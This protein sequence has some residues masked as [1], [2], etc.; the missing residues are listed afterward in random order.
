MIHPSRKILL[1]IILCLSFCV[2]NHAFVIIPQHNGSI[3]TTED[4]IINSTESTQRKKFKMA[5]LAAKPK[6]NIVTSAFS[7]SDDI[8]ALEAMFPFIHDFILSPFHV[9]EMI[10]VATKDISKL[11][12][13]MIFAIVGY[14]MPYVGRYIRNTLARGRLGK[15]TKLEPLSPPSE[16][17]GYM[18]TKWYHVFN[19]VRQGFYLGAINYVIDF[20]QDSIASFGVH[21][22]I[23]TII[24]NF[25]TSSR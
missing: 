25:C 2:V 21:A 14:S 15:L 19:H 8:S 7:R 5:P 23:V 10:E 1:F 13:T 17:D 12:R 22:K 3:R 4:N 24:S 11:S 9:R 20:I 6:P 16:N 18:I